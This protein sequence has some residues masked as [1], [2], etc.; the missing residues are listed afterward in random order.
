MATSSTEPLVRPRF[1]DVPEHWRHPLGPYRQAPEEHGGEWWMVNPFTGREPWLFEDRIRQVPVLPEGF[2]EIFGPRPT[3]ALFQRTPN[4]AFA[5]RSAVIVW[6]QELRYFKRQGLP[7]WATPPEVAEAERIFQAWEIGR[8]RYYEGRY[9]WMAR[10][11][12]SQIK[13]YDVPV[14]TA[15]HWTHGTIAHYQIALA[16]QGILPAKKHPLVSPHIWT[17]ELELGKEVA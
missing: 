14:W 12:E 3:M 2:L 15:L 6:E 16:S 10:L 11:V 4:A 17:P 13:D 7:E 5:Y 9:N 8:P 1:K